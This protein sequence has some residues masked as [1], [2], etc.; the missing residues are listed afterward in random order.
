[1]FKYIDSFFE[2]IEIEHDEVVSIHSPYSR[3]KYSLIFYDGSYK[4]SYERS[5]DMVKRFNSEASFDDQLIFKTSGK[6][7]FY[8]KVIGRKM[9]RET[10]YT[11]YSLLSMIPFVKKYVEKKEEEKEDIDDVD[12]FNENDD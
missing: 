3:K 9:K 8:I 10:L 7:E 6:Q 1:M 4:G 2:T 11:I 12:I 5:E